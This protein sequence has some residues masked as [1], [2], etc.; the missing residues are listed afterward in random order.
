MPF[1]HAGAVSLL[2][3]QRIFVQDIG[4]ITYFKGGST[5]VRYFLNVAGMGYDA[6]VAKKTNLLKEKGRGG[7]L[8]YLWF[9]FSSLFQF[10]FLDAV[11]EVDGKTV[12]KG[13]IFSMNVG[14][15]KYNGGGMMQVPF[16]V[17]DDGL[18]DIT[19]IV[20]TSKWMVIRHANKL[21]NG[22][23]VNLPIV[24]T[25]QG[26]TIRVRSTGKLFLEADGESLGH[27][28]FTFE[29]L[30]RAL[31]VITHDGPQI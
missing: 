24:K 15:C 7:P 18:L 6:L 12:F 1:D 20:K 13:E 21:Y 10:T 19:L 22:T 28:P 29:V 2:K 8:T 30:P 23:L 26:K 31:N 16:A 3:Q 5:N 4:K 9:V 17:A 14:I 25:F 11:I 27:S